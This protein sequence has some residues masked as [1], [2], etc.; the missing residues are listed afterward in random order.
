MRIDDR[1]LDLECLLQSA[2]HRS[3]NCSTLARHFETPS[4][5]DELL[6]MKCGKA[7]HKVRG[8]AISDSTADLLRDEAQQRAGVMAFGLIPPAQSGTPDP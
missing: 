7:Q 3:R 2:P 6:I 1:L 5:R 8:P 4:D